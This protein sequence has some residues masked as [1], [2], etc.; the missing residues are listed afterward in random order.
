VPAKIIYTKAG[1][2]CFD[3]IP[4]ARC[5]SRAEIG[6]AFQKIELMEKLYSIYQMI[7]YAAVQDVPCRNF[8]KN[9]LFDANVLPLIA[10][11][12]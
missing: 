10:R 3:E 5:L 2:L 1:A 6:N 4:L 11:F 9:K 7:K 8:I 12:M